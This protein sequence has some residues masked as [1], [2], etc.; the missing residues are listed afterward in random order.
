M[1]EPGKDERERN[2]EK[3]D[4]T[5]PEYGSVCRINAKFFKNI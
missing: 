5:R 4:S 3:W 1:E 2:M